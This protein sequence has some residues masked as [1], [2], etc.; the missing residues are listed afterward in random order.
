MEA[1]KIELTGRVNYVDIKYNKS[2]M[3][4]ARTAISKKG[5]DDDYN[6]YWVTLFGETAENY[7]NT[8]NKG[9]TAN[10]TGKLAINKYEKDGKTIER[11]ELYG[12]NFVKA[13]YDETT[14]KYVEDEKMPWNE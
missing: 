9:D 7:A 10:I 3:A 13:K 5:K 11:L 4:V 8:I 12:D 14:H 1:N 2:G 6:T